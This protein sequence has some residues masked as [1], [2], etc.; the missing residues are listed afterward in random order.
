MLVLSTKDV[1]KSFGGLIAV[2]QFSFD[3]PEGKIYSVIGPNGAGKTT[4]FN[5]ITGFYGFEDGKIEFMGQV[6]NGK[7]PDQI[8]NLGISRTYQNIRLFSNMTAIENI[9]VGHHPHFKTYWFEALIP[10]KRILQEEAE[11]LE[12][13]VHLLNYVG[14]KGLGDQLACNL[15]YGAQRRLE[16]ARALANR[17]KLLLLDEPTAGMNP[18]ETA[19]M[20]EFIQRLRDEL[21]ITI[22]LIEHDMKVVMSISENIGVMD[23]GTKIAEGTPK[24]IQRNPQVIEAYLGRGAADG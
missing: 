6:L 22:L 14:L 8:T 13:A 10:T 4:F 24:E 7:S 11:A 3:L 15:P 16:I 23:F 21:G 5:C 1:T 20:I 18:N 19:E 9:L 12:E 17:P 2:N